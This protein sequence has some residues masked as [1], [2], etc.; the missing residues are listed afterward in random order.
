MKCGPLILAST[1][2]LS[3]VAP[4]AGREAA[5]P[6]KRVV[7]VA[8]RKSHESTVH[9]YPAGA[10][11]LAEVAGQSGL[12]WTVTAAKEWPADTAAIADAD[13]VVLYSDGL[14]DHVAK[15]RAAELRQRLNTGKGLVVLHF[16]LE[17][18]EDD[19]AL[20]DV[21]RDAVGGVFESGWS[22]NP[23]WKADLTVSPGSPAAR[24]LER[25]TV[26]DEIYFHLRFASG[27]GQL[28]PVLTAMPSPDVV[29]TDGP[30]SG[31]ADV[32]AA[33]ARGEPQTLAW[34][35]IAESGARGFGFTGGHSHR[36]WY[37]PMFRRTV[38]NGM[39]WAAGLDV[40]E[41][42][43]PVGDP[44]VPQF[45]SVDEAI[46]RG[47][48][49]D[50]RRHLRR[51]PALANGRPGARLAP[52]HQAILRR[53]ADIVGFLLAQGADPQG[54]DA[55]SR[56]PL[57]MAVERGDPAVV[58]LLLA[59]GATNE[60]RDRVGWTPLHHAAAGDKVEIARLLLDGGANPNALS[61]LG[62]T[63]LHEAAASG[64]AAMVR[65]LLERGTDPNHRSK[66]GVTALDIARERS[67]A[68]AVGLLEAVAKH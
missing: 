49:A 46:A 66:P 8:G 56:T 4:G 54:T 21:L 41:G 20:R 18:P 31:N 50:V 62:G 10:D 58:R 61:E 64:G 44:A 51:E 11:L 37:E 19:P 5:T 67:N 57:H 32:R 30:R 24:G 2:L 68:V 38:L 13:L 47:D 28:D 29:S 1:L 45:A 52:L 55:S 27:G 33:I 34:T 36:L 16:A 23:V 17:P 26:T 59:K 39:A 48:L 43:V 9:E 22:V 63:P 25:L 14:A 6:A 35:W 40:P 3:C 42:G 7:I 65:L 12:P 60:A 53:R 15:G